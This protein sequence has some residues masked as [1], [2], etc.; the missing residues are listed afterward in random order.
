MDSLSPPHTHT[1]THKKFQHDLLATKRNNTNPVEKPY[2]YTHAYIH[3]LYTYIHTYTQVNHN[4]WLVSAFT[5]IPLYYSCISYILKQSSKTKINDDKLDLP[6]AQWVRLRNLHEHHNHRSV[7]PSHVEHVKHSSIC[8]HDILCYNNKFACNPSHRQSCILMRN[9]NVFTSRKR[10]R[11]FN[12]DSPT[13][14]CNSHNSS[15]QC[16]SYVILTGS[17]IT[18]DEE[19]K[20]IKN[21]PAHYDETLLQRVANTGAATLRE[22]I[23]VFLIETGWLISLY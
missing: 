7:F 19:P 23:D 14:T 10:V 8:L 21:H 1:S 18:H 15:M 4:T 22:S 6:D 5:Y 20:L 2:I 11:R 3:T 13:L 9:M 16:C 12:C 17:D